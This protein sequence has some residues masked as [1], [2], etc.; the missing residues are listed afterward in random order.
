MLLYKIYLM[1]HQHSG[2]VATVFMPRFSYYLSSQLATITELSHELKSEN[3]PTKKYTSL[4][5]LTFG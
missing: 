4:Q 5:E 3:C 2:D 1:K